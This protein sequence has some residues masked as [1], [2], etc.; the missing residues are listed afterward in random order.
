MFG[1]S[2]LARETPVPVVSFLYARGRRTWAASSVMHGA[3]A[4]CREP[5]R[6]QS[7]RLRKE[8]L[9]MKRQFFSCL[10]LV[11][12]ALLLAAC[13][14]SGPDAQPLAVTVSGLQYQP[15][16]LEVAA[17]Q[18]VRLTLTNSDALEHDF[19]ITEFPVDG[20]VQTVGHG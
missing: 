6:R 11:G 16:A 13:A 14:G 9:S 8:N 3:A 19:S 10:V 2:L 5:W 12:M 7:S 18:P 17:G 15:S 20:T 4:R 1:T